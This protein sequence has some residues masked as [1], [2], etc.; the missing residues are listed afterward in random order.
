MRRRALDLPVFVLIQLL[1]RKQSQFPRG[2]PSSSPARVSIVRAF[3]SIHP[4]RAHRTHVFF[5]PE[6]AAGSSSCVPL[7]SAMGIRA[8]HHM[9]VRPALC[10]FIF[11][12]SIFFFTFTSFFVVHDRY[13]VLPAEH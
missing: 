3:N 2:W 13:V 11:V 9:S 4:W 5:R 6:V 10:P 8:G 12:L 7:A 1:L